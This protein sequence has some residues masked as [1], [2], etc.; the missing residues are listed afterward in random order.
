MI[1]SEFK[2]L[3]ENAIN[4]A[5]KDLTEKFS[6]KVEELKAEIKSL[7]TEIKIIKEGVNI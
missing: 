6:S 1:P 5:T 7:R 4:Q 3:V 2:V